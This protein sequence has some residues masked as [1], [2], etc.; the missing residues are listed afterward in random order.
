MIDSLFI[1][2]IFNINI[3]FIKKKQFFCM[4]RMISRE[5]FFK[6]TI[7]KYLKKSKK[8]CLVPIPFYFFIFLYN[9]LISGPT[10]RE[11]SGSHHDRK[12]QES[13]IFSIQSFKMLFPSYNLR[14]SIIHWNCCSLFMLLL[15]LIAI[16]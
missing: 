13:M 11:R 7:G 12:K 16:P 15:I 2:Y 6:N 1:K 3:D 5:F 4:M 8:K 9:I 10:V 14:V